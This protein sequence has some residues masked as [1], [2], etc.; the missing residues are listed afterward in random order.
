MPT[1]LKNWLGTLTDV[2]RDEWKPVALMLFYG[3]LAMTSY[4]VVKP[5]RNA[6]FVD[7]VGS[8]N[9]PYVYIITAIVVSLVMVGYSR[10][11]SRI[12]HLTLL[13]GTFAF[14]ASNLVL[15]RWLLLQE[16]FLVSGIFYVW[17][18]LYPLLLVS[19]FYLVGNLLFTTRQ[20]KR[21]F[22]PIGVGLIM[23]GIAGSS[24]A[25]W[26]TAALGTENLLLLAAGMLGVC[27]MLV[28]AL[29]PHMGRGEDAGSRRLVGKVSGD[30]IRLL[31]QSA[32][33]RWIAIILMTTILV[34]TLIDWQFNTAVDM[35]I[36]G[37][38]EK[39]EF[40][41]RFFLALNIA[42]VTIQ[43]LFTS[44][45]LRKWGVGVALL[46]LPAGLLLTSVGIF[47]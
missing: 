44:F 17:G 4:Y 27:A 1:A 6:I 13:L 8:E 23:G 5:A 45:V 26:S 30:A 35:F 41:G 33:L 9:L 22:G 24:V 31:F 28:L 7:R 19:Q 39:T 40:F 18:K 16:T 11:V 46:A 25:G 36:P 43:L 42:S 20:A 14:L 38:D 34:T 2:R 15:F 21:L 32:H 37:E 12:K 29:S 3:F 10:W 47:L